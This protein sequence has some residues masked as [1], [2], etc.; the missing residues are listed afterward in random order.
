MSRHTRIGR[1][2]WLHRIGHF[3][4]AG[5]RSGAGARRAEKDALPRVLAAREAMPALA[6]GLL[7]RR[8]VRL[9]RD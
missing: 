5:K 6:S 4:L 2:S 1:N 8:Q 9:R 3:L 7:D